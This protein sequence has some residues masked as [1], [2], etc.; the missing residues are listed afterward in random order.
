MEVNHYCLL[1]IFHRL[2]HGVHIATPLPQLLLLMHRPLQR[3]LA[4]R[5]FVGIFET[6]RWVPRA[7]L[8]CAC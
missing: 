4:R 5:I 3:L 8:F 1:P 6:L 7:L 2:Y